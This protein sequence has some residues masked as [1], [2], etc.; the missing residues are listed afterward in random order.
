MNDGVA[1]VVF[2]TVPQDRSREPW[3]SNIDGSCDDL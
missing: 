3:S 1:I 2:M